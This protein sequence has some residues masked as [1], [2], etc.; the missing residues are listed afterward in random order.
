MKT[1]SL[2]ELA[3]ITMVAAVP[4][5][6]SIEAMA[7]DYIE[8]NP[9]GA[10]GEDYYT[11][12][13]QLGPNSI[14]ANA[15]GEDYSGDTCSGLYNEVLTG[16]SIN[17]AA[18][19]SG[20]ISGFTNSG[21]S[22]GNNQANNAR[23]VQRVALNGETGLAGSAGAGSFNAWLA[24]AYARTDYSYDPLDSDG[25][26][27]VGMFGLDYTF[28]NNVVLGV[29]VTVDRTDVDTNY[30]DGK[31]ENDGYSIAPYVAW[32]ITPNLTLDASAG[33]GRSDVDQNG[34]DPFFVRFNSSTDNDRRFAAL[35]L[36]YNK[37]IGD[38]RL[39]G[40]GN[41]LYAKDELDSF[42]DSNGRS[43]S[44]SSTSL[45]QLRL[46]G[47]AMYVMQNFAP[48]VGLSYVNDLSRDDQDTLLGDRPANDDNSV[49]IQAGVNIYGS[50]KLSG[51]VML[52]SEQGRSEVDNDQILANISY[53]F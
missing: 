17:N 33:W 13:I 10:S 49:I 18:N 23:G 5:T 51:G 28:S 50:G 2:A 39:T 46:G 29:A 38:W 1:K 19:L 15:Y 44:S 25:H 20:I 32:G 6:A 24:Y 7:Y 21:G 4:A 43:F 35:G 36:S 31:L 52:Q 41:L 45:T 34:D 30:N 42:T 47:Q 48:Y 26:S 16:V 3:M 40:R 12:N 37:D 14:S 53:S 8:P 27:N 22:G 11:D 9:C